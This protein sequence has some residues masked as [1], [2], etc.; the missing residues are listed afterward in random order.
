MVSLTQGRNI[1]L[2]VKHTRTSQVRKTGCTA[3]LIFFS[4]FAEAEFPIHESLRKT[5]Q[6]FGPM[7]GTLGFNVALI[8]LS[9]MNVGYPFVASISLMRWISGSSQ[10]GEQIFVARLTRHLIR[11]ILCCFELKESN[12]VYW[13]VNVGF[14]NTDVL[15]TVVPLSG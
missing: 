8:T 11:L 7:S 6:R 4:K 13:P 14:L 1:G 3:R 12:L 10:H 5:G 9:T 2:D 15:I